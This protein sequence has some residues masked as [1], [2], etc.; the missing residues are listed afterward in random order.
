VN[1]SRPL[2]DAGLAITLLTALP[3]KV[4]TP[5]D[6]ER[7][8]AASWFPF[9]GL[10]IG[11]A[12]G[13]IVW[14]ADR[15]FYG[16]SGLAA[17]LLLLVMAVVTRLIHYDGLADTADGWFVAPA[18]RLDVMADSHTGAFG[19][20]A[21]VL[22]VLIQWNALVDLGG[23]SLTAATVVFAPVL[24]RCAATFSA[25]FG[26]PARAGGL[27][28][29]IVGR[30]T[31]GG[32]VATVGSL[33]A[34]FLLAVALGAGVLVAASTG[35]LGLVLALVV[36]HLIALRFGGVTGDTMGASVLI[37]ETAVMV[38]ALTLVAIFRL[39]GVSA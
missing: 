8:D 27:G 22:I 14:L 18:R 31:V 3:L 33:G 30:P 20:A 1:R 12:L 26:T 29:S 17:A 7:V 32:L 5:A 39:L 11:T 28:A 6:S 36:P 10:A 34:A 25:W 35:I 9:V 21:I 24:G 2:R 37:V 16:L 15:Y 38:L 23:S 19:A 4:R 13:G